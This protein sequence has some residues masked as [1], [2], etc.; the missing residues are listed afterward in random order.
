MILNLLNLDEAFFFDKEMTI[1]A[2]VSSPLSDVILQ[3]LYFLLY[4]SQY[5]GSGVP[6]DLNV[7]SSK[8]QIL[9]P[10]GLW[11]PLSVLCVAV[12]LPLV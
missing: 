7:G 4:I 1:F 10:V 2:E 12:R 6:L 5:W 8:C 3:Y 9:G 11:I